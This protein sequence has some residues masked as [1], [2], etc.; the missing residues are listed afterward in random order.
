M[1]TGIFNTDQ[2]FANFHV[3]QELLKN[4][5]LN[6]LQHKNKQHAVE[7]QSARTKGICTAAKILNL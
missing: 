2:Q 4:M 7:Q 5:M 1:D 6:A 3:N